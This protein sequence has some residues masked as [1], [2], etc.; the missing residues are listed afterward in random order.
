MLKV[1]YLKQLRDLIK[2]RRLLFAILF[3]SL[4]MIYFP[5]RLFIKMGHNEIIMETVI[6]FYFIFYSIMVVLLLTFSANYNLFLQEKVA[7]T[8]HSLLSTPLDIKTIWLGKTLAIFTIGYSLS[9]ILSFIFLLIVNSS[10]ISDNTIFPSM[11]GYISLLAINPFI[12]VFLIGNIGIWTLV[13]KDE[14]K[15]RIGFM[16]FMFASMYFF[17]PSKLNLGLS[18]IPYQII[19][20]LI[21]FVA[22]NIS[23]K[24]LSNEKVILS[25]E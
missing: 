10:S 21:L 22:T 24:F 17:Q 2:G 23:L 11:H 4:F 12:C 19:F 14:T 5:Y 8:I 13:S 1:V 15:V 25:I 7:K 16:I 9:F 6:D 20:L 18:I 3:A